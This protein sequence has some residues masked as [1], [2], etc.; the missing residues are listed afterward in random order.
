MVSLF[1]GAVMLF[2]SPNITVR[3]W[4]TCPSQTFCLLLCV[5]FLLGLFLPIPGQCPASWL[6]GTWAERRIIALTSCICFICFP[7]DFSCSFLNPYFFCLLLWFLSS[8]FTDAHFTYSLTVYS[9]IS[10]RGKNIKQTK[11][12]NTCS[13]M[14]EKLVWCFPSRH[15]VMRS[16]Y[17]GTWH[18]SLKWE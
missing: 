3:P 8:W 15:L 11:V 14:R 1:A 17:L 6:P 5:V 9:F 16:H 12:E 2:W 10:L 13:L 18:D 7:L 4:Q